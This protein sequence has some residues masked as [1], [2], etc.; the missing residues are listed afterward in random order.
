MSNSY[1]N[2]AT[3]PTPNSPGSSAQLR[4]EL[5]SITAGFALLPTLA[6]NGYKVAM[7]NSAGTAMTASSAL[8]ALA[9]TASTF[10]SNWRKRG[11][12]RHVYQFDRDWYS[13]AWLDYG[14]HWR[15]DQ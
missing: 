14:D 6:A 11:R 12:G 3:Y 7:I 13:L 4:A 8:Q 15:Y 1:Y 5:E 2:H 9:I 10:N